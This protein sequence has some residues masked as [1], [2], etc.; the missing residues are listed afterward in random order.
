MLKIDLMWALPLLSHPYVNLDEAT[1]AR[2]PSHP[3][4]IFFL[5]CSILSITHTQ[6]L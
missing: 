4:F 1:Y 6:S 2:L 5:S 3:P